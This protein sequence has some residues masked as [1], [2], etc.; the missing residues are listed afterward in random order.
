MSRLRRLALHSRLFFV[1]TN[2]LRHAPAFCDVEFACV[3]DVL[4]GAR[5]RVPFALCGYCLMPDHLHAIIFPQETTTISEVMRRFKLS[6][7]Q[8]LR[9]A[10]H[11]RDPFWQGR[12]YDRALRTRREFDEALDYMH[13]NPVRRGLAAHPAAW[14]W[15]SARWFEEESGPVR[16]DVMRLPFDERATLRKG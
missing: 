16:V 7:Y 2:L 11:R 4:G 5:Q 8:T 14:P 9:A 15:S 13:M 6:A 10:G 1:T 3:A 12:F